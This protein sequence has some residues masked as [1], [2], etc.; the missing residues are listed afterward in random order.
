MTHSQA[1]LR[2]VGNLPKKGSSSLTRLPSHHTPMTAALQME[3]VLRQ[4]AKSTLQQA[5]KNLAGK[6]AAQLAFDFDVP[7]ECALAR[8]PSWHWALLQDLINAIPLGLSQPGSHTAHSDSAD[9]T[10]A[11]PLPGLPLRMRQESPKHLPGPLGYCFGGLLNCEAVSML[12]VKP[13]L[14]V[15]PIWGQVQRLLGLAPAP[16]N[17]GHPPKHG[18]CPQTP[19]GRSRSIG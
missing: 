3:H 13:C 9:S 18:P 16:G 12:A 10:Q 5:I 7:T 17:P 11:L 1:G 4:V 2:P 15:V 14:P 8:P 19:S 6:T